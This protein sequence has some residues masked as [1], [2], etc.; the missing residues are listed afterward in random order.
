MD[1]HI[2]IH[3]IKLPEK[4]DFSKR[5]NEVSDIFQKAMDESLPKEEQD[6]YWKA[7]WQKKYCLEQGI[8]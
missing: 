4:D 1:I 2:H 6:A 8:Y 7:Y 5:F 3:Q